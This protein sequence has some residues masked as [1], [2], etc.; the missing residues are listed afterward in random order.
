V[1]SPRNINKQDIII[2]FLGFIAWLIVAVKA[3]LIPFTIDE[4][5]TYLDFVQS[6]NFIPWF[7]KW[8]ANNHVLNSFLTI[9][10]SS[11]FGDKPFALRLP[12]VLAFGMFVFQVKVFA[13]KRIHHLSAAAALT[14]LLFYSSIVVEFFS[15]CRG[16]GI[17][18]ALLMWF[19][20]SLLR[21][22]KDSKSNYV[23]LISSGALMVS[24]NL[25]LLPTYIAGLVL[26][27]VI[28]LRSGKI[29]GPPV[30]IWLGIILLFLAQGVALKESGL[31][32]YGTNNFFE[33]TLGYTAALYLG[34]DLLFWYFIPVFATLIVHLILKRSSHK[35]GGDFIILFLLLLAAFIAPIAQHV[36][37]GSP[38]PQ[39]RTFM[40]V[41]MLTCLVFALFM[42][43]NSKLISGLGLA[44]SSIILF[45]FFSS[46]KLDRS[47]LWPGDVIAEGTMGELM[48][49]HQDN[50]EPPIVISDYAFSSV[51]DYTNAI[52][53]AKIH[54]FKPDQTESNICLTADYFL[55]NDQSPLPCD[56]GLIDT[57]CFDPKANY[58]L[59]KRKNSPSFSVESEGKQT[60]A[61]PPSREFYGLFEDSIATDTSRSYVLNIES[62]LTLPS[63][64]SEFQLVVEQKS[65]V[66][67][68][69]MA[70][71]LY[72]N[73]VSYQVSGNETFQIRIPLNTMA[74]SSLVA[75]FWNLQ[76]LDVHYDQSVVKLESRPAH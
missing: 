56:L 63:D 29:K 37:L 55:V 46:F 66:E 74:H 52:N 33:M 48:K 69:R 53:H 45:G 26:I 27:M 12:N 35:E 71:D 58:S 49:F 75:Y 59:I 10:S 60:K 3:F 43:Q 28:K 62:G 23:Q 68:R 47:L 34:S 13:Q 20:N 11:L 22:S 76:H 5:A 70:I 36:L 2:L 16:Y 41:M 38:F 24:A 32:Y 21:A 39:D 64:G 9:L 15:L 54:Y 57:V 65:K 61:F 40:H 30:A 25:N 18:L 19:I 17:S 67:T 7:S 50:G 1:F 73:F 14:L 42:D 6:R 4:A 72:R 51:W 31:L 8:E 44:Y